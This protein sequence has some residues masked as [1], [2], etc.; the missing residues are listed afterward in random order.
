MLQYRSPFQAGLIGSSKRRAELVSDFKKKQG[1]SSD[2]IA[3]IERN[4]YILGAPWSFDSAGPKM[5]LGDYDKP[6]SKLLR[7]YLYQFLRDTT[8][9]R[10]VIK[11]R[12]CL[13]PNT[14]I[15]I[16]DKNNKLC[17][18][19]IE[20]LYRSDYKGKVIYY[21]N[22]GSL[23]SC[24]IEK[25][26][27]SGIK[28]ILEIKTFDGHKLECSPREKI[29]VKDKFKLAKDIA[30]G[31]LLTTYQIPTFKAS[32]QTIS[33]NMAKA[34]GYM[35]SDGSFFVTG[36]NRVICYFRNKSKQYAYDFMKLVG[37]KYTRI[38][39]F[40]ND[41]SFGYDVFVRQDAPL[42]KKLLD[43]GALGIVNEHKKIPDFILHEPKPVISNFLN[44][45]FAGDGYYSI[46]KRPKY[47]TY[48]RE[49]GLGSMSYAMLI[50]IQFMLY[51]FGINSS[52]KES[53][54][55][56]S[57]KEFWKL[58]V[59]SKREH[60]L[61]FMQ[62][63]G[64]YGK[65]KSNDIIKLKSEIKKSEGR[66]HSHR[67]KKP[68][69]V[70]SIKEKPNEMTY[71]ITVSDKEH[72]RFFANGILVS[73]S[74]FTENHVN[75]ALYYALTRPHTS[76]SHIFP[77][78]DL[79]YDVSNEKIGPAIKES[80]EI[81]KQ[82]VQPG[83][84]QRYMFHTGGI[85]SIV[86]SLKKSGGRAVARDILIWDEV[87]QIS[88][89]IFGV[90]EETLSHSALKLKRYVSTPTVP[91]IGIDKIVK[92][93]CEYE[94]W[95]VCP[96]CKEAQLFTFPDNLINNFERTGLDMD[97]PEYLKKLNKVYIGCS[98]CKTYINRNT[99]FYVKSSKWIAKKPELCNER[100]SY[101]VNM[102]MVPWK[103]GKEIMRRFHEL[104][105]YIW[106][107]YN[108]CIGIAYIKGENRLAE[109]EIMQC[110]APWQ[111]LRNRIAVLQNVSIGVD[112]GEKESW[113]VVSAN[114]VSAS[115]PG[116]RCVIYLERIDK[117]SL[118][119]AGLKND[120]TNHHVRVGQIMDVFGADIL[121]NDAN[122]IGMDRNRHLI[123]KFPKRVWGCFFDTAEQGRQV[124]QS[125]LQ[126][127]QW[128][129]VQ[130]KVTISKVMALKELQLEYRR[131]AISI[132]V[133]RGEKAD[134]VKQFIRQQ[135]ALGIQPRWNTEFQ[136]QFETVVKMHP[137]DHFADAHMYS[138]VGWDKLT[139]GRF[140]IPGVVL[141]T[142][143][144]GTTN[145]PIGV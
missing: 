117:E 65:I 6:S 68:N 105:D 41:T 51:R 72:H 16:L 17:I 94:W 40:K 86:G 129:E 106:Q 115:D 109:P 43:I 142:G 111:M 35:Y 46:K 121:I 30:K 138:K 57:K 95:V 75:E 80:P 53:K 98:S 144:T 135:T 22:D 12:Q 66:R 21:D 145:R 136:R 20:N 27:Q 25:I 141:K 3:W 48:T 132:P 134:I 23:K 125:K 11:C 110:L 93:G 1:L 28:P 14:A 8:S 89:A 76:I 74:E 101:Y 122:G 84:V 4:R 56:K 123:N 137:D 45:L 114:G 70:V 96:K 37:T 127:P 85:Y 139:G 71:D 82:L 103:T 88:E 83:A 63:I 19:T 126:V 87:D 78:D 29:W 9:D 2:I 64:I 113:V 90:Y 112:W 81:N 42:R 92:A 10:S 108:E 49:I 44:R 130:R 39:K 58:V 50:Q 61:K 140:R 118:E 67:N 143:V 47:P 128:S 131:K 104:E 33:K 32:K 73:N 102:F 100:A 15:F 77:T 69:V 55:K 24:Y 13:V 62:E 38:N 52:I 60:V 119:R 7:P 31:D 18:E 107:F 124:R 36:A 54:S 133:D 34:L 79:G 116:K 120:T 26:W 5:E 97:S 99:Q 91:L 59:S